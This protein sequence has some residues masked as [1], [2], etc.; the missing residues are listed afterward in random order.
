MDPL[1]R[2]IL[3][4]DARQEERI[5]VEPLEFDPQRYIANLLGD[6]EFL[7]SLG[8][9]HLGVVLPL[10]T[11]DTS[12]H[13]RYK[14]HEVL[15]HV[16][17]D[18]VLEENDLPRINIS[19]RFAAR[20]RDLGE[21]IRQELNSLESRGGSLT[22]YLASEESGSEQEPSEGPL[23]RFFPVHHTKML[24]ASFIEDYIGDL[25]YLVPRVKTMKELRVLI[26]LGGV[27]KHLK[28]DKK[29][30][31]DMEISKDDNSLLDNFVYALI[32]SSSRSTRSL[33]ISSAKTYRNLIENRKRFLGK[34]RKDRERFKYDAF[35]N[36]GRK[37]RNLWRHIVEVMGIVPVEAISF[38]N[39][40]AYPNFRLGTFSGGTNALGI[41]KDK[42][43]TA[44]AQGFRVIK[45]EARP[46]DFVVAW[47]NLGD[48]TYLS[49]DTLK[50]LPLETL[51][52]ISDNGRFCKIH[53][54]RRFDL[55]PGEYLILGESLIQGGVKIKN[56]Y[57]RT[58]GEFKVG[59]EVEVRN[60]SRF[61]YVRPGS[62]GHV[63]GNTRRNFIDVEFDY[64]I[65]EYE[66]RVPVVHAV[67]RPSLFLRDEKA[68]ERRKR[69]H[70]RV[71]REIAAQFEGVYDALYRKRRL[72]LRR[73]NSYLSKSLRTFAD[74]GIDEDLA[75]VIIRRE[76]R[77]F[78][79]TNYSTKRFITSGM[80]K[81]DRK[82]TAQRGFGAI[83][84]LTSMGY[85]V[86]EAATD[87]SLCGWNTQYNENT[88]YKG[89][90][91]WII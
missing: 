5:V 58:F 62:R 67:Y 36:D 2:A 80:I 84:T 51:G 39:R 40:Q 53:S 47:S 83:A 31:M 82:A 91:L 73:R 20:A 68:K 75:R 18:D 52:I 77:G 35:Q 9:S 24:A 6:G 1:L 17:L 27:Y 29:A 63:V 26:A 12:R 76:F 86:E 57:R 71:K 90:R 15:Y 70:K 66:D 7:E 72:T 38:D 50:D 37:G 28:P 22:D 60:T 19:G 14:G 81:A 30:L 43:I 41:N 16:V 11:S 56:R 78:L 87:L 48:G 69:R 49:G 23:G 21:I 13:P 3:E 42:T 25:E 79:P 10:V 34:F 59:D 88:L 54:S 46:D 45:R 44:L 61:R 74:L 64:V 33:D 89:R 4:E 55:E 8:D 32:L 85:S 65:G